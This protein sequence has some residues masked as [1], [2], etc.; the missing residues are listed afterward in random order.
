[1]VEFRRG[2]FGDIEIL[3]REMERFFDRLSS[4][5]PP[6]VRFSPRVWQPS[7]DVY[8]MEEEIVVLVEL[9]GMSGE[10]V[11]VTLSGDKLQ[12]KGE[13]Q[14]CGEGTRRTYHQMEI[15]CGIF[16][17]TIDLPAPVDPE[18]AKASYQDGIL[19]IVMPKAR[20]ALTHKVKIR[21]S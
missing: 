11:D 20:E 14:T 2:P 3:Q 7:I 13:R 21:T 5:K 18:R 19:E 6:V 1:M 10:D 17:R 4:A 16:E 9:A 15:P 12:V 8:E